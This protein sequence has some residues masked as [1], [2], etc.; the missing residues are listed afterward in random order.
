MRMVCHWYKAKLGA[1]TV[2]I[3]AVKYILYL[4]NPNQNNYKEK[5]NQPHKTQNQQKPKKKA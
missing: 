4:K 5:A 2:S 3:S 1:K